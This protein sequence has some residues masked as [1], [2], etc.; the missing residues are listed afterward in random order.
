M[1]AARICIAATA[2]VPKTIGAG[3]GEMALSQVIKITELPL[4]A[5]E[6]MMALTVP[7]RKLSPAIRGWIR[8]KSQDPQEWRATTIHHVVPVVCGLPRKR[9]LLALRFC[10]SRRKGSGLKVKAEHCALTGE[11]VRW[12][13]REVRVEISA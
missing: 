5:F 9:Q 7:S 3:T 6:D 1:S 2:R 13:G 11:G 10:C 8:E 12:V 4:Q